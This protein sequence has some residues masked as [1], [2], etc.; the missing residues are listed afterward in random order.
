MPQNT[1]QAKLLR[2]TLIQLH[3]AGIALVLSLTASIRLVAQRSFLTTCGNACYVRRIL[4]HRLVLADGRGELVEH[5]GASGMQS[6]PAEQ[7]SVMKAPMSLSSGTPKSLSSETRSVSGGGSGMSRSQS[8]EMRSVSGGNSAPMSLSSETRSVSGGGAPMSLSSSTL[9]STSSEARSVSGGGAPRTGPHSAGRGQVP[10]SASASLEGMN[11]GTET[12]GGGTS[13]AGGH[14]QLQRM[15][16]LVKWGRLGYSESTWEDGQKIGDD[17]AIKAYGVSRKRWDAP[18]TTPAERR[19]NLRYSEF[20]KLEGAAL[21]DG[22]GGEGE[23]REL[24]DYQVEG[25]NWL[26][27]CAYH[28]RGCILGDEMGLVRP[29]SQLM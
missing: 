29:F 21:V 1:V 24:R 15:E 22:I 9:R 6:A 19:E 5:A 13:S 16:Y 17:E 14:L 4:D 23:L 10:T 26:R 7:I 20:V 18:W 11:V 27:F 12:T 8:T 28:R 2:R 25:I 3:A